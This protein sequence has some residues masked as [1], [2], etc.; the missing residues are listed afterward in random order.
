MDPGTLKAF[1]VHLLVCSFFGIVNINNKH[2]IYTVPYH[3]N[4][5]TLSMSLVTYILFSSP[6]DRDTEKSLSLT[7]LEPLTWDSRAL[8]LDHPCH[9]VLIRFGKGRTPIRCRTLASFNCLGLLR[10]PSSSGSPGRSS[11]QQPSE[12]LLVPW[13]GSINSCLDRS[14]IKSH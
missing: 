2:F 10:P 9:Q 6:I 12:L 1:L 8:P 14:S 5:R 4:L 7:G 11:H 13:C 3:V